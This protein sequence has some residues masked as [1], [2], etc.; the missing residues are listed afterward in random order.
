MELALL[1]SVGMMVHPIK[2]NPT[3][4]VQ[5]K[6]NRKVQLDNKLI[7]SSLHPTNSLTTIIIQF[8]RGIR[9]ATPH[10]NSK[11]TL[12]IP[13]NNKAVG[14][15]TKVWVAQLKKL[16]LGFQISLGVIKVLI[17]LAGRITVIT[18]RKLN[19]LVSNKY[20]PNNVKNNNNPNTR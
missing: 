20:K 16:P 10:N 14:G 11:D 9:V 7:N 19:M 12:I 5:A 1:V 17:F 8:N 18:P 13:H 2:L 6:I 15:Q 4:T 3:L